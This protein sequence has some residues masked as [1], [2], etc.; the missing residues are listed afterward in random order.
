MKSSIALAALFSVAFALPDQSAASCGI[1]QVLSYMKE[2]LTPFTNTR[3]SANRADCYDWCT[4]GCSLGSFDWWPDYRPNGPQPGDVHI[5]LACARHD[6][7]YRN[8][9]MFNNF[10]QAHKK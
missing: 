4:D 10:T 7:A 9:K 5:G 1:N 6:F 2:P 3:K 8:L